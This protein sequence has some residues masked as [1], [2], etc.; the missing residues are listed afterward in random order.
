MGDLYAPPCICARSGNFR[1]DSLSV[2]NGYVSEL[3]FINWRFRE[4]VPVA[5]ADKRF[6]SPFCLLAVVVARV[7]QS[8]VASSSAGKHRA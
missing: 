2:T 1:L 3:I 7:H 5:L 8:L 6:H 4:D